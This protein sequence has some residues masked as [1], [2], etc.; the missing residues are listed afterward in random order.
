MKK[1]EMLGK[2]LDKA[3]Q[4][5]VMGGAKPNWS[6]LILGEFCDTNVWQ[7]PCCDGYYCQTSGGGNQG[8]CQYLVVIPGD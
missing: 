8:W 6:C 5:N 1:L 3:D 7:H 2:K 4:K